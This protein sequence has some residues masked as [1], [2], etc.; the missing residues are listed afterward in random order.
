MP[1]P[2]AVEQAVLSAN[3]E[4]YAAF[5][6]GDLDAMTDLWVPEGHA[7]CIHPGWSPVVG[8]AAVRRSWAVIMANTPYIQFILTD[9][10]VTVVG[11]VASVT[12][13]ENVL[14]AD[15]ETPT[16]GFSGGKAVTTNVFRRTPAAGANS[17]RL[18]IH[19]ASPVLSTTGSDEG[20]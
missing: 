10:D 12:C 19:H 13:T 18:W 4:F 20:A 11:D 9:V 14:S 1:D 2:T 17:W 7:V 15:E 3:S 8:A 5:E 16:E 6:S